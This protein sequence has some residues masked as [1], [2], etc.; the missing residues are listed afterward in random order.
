GMPLTDALGVEHDVLYDL[1]VNGNRPDAMS[2]AGVARDLAARLKVPFSIPEPKA[3]ETGAD[4]TGRATVEILDP[5][6][7]GRF[8]A[9]VLDNVQVGPSPQWLQSRLRAVGQR[10]INNVVDVSNYVMFELG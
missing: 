4:A 9:R 8:V 3:A 7:C 2:V 5:D 6:L 10:P 1:E